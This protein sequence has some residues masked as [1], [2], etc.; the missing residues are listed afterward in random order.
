MNISTEHDLGLTAGI[1][2][3]PLSIVLIAPLKLF[4]FIITL[5]FERLC[6]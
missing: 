1:G 3:F 5:D 6:A 4:S 2:L